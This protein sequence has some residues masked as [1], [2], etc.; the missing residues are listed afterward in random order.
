M[1]V[2]WAEQSREGNLP[3]IDPQTAQEWENAIPSCSDVTLL[4]GGRSCRCKKKQGLRV[5]MIDVC[6][7]RP[8][9]WAYNPLKGGVTW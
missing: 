2:P 5:C 9:L 4:V 1:E 8:E 3:P 6:P 7:R